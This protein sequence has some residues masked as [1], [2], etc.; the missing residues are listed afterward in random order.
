MLLCKCAIIF[1]ILESDLFCILKNLFL[2]SYCNY[3]Q[4]ILFEHI[5]EDEITE[6]EAFVRNEMLNVILDN[7]ESIDENGDTKVNK[8]KMIEYFGELYALK[9]EQ[10]RFQPGDR[11]FIK[12]IQQTIT[13]TIEKKGRKRAMQHFGYK[14]KP[15]AKKML[16]DNQSGHSNTDDTKCAT[17]DDECTTVDIDL[18]KKMKAK[19]FDS[20]LDKLKTF[21]IPQN[22]IEMF[23]DSFISVYVGEDGMVKGDVVCVVCHAKKVQPKKNKPNHVYCR[24]KSGNLS[25]VISNFVKHFQRVHSDIKKC[26]KKDQ[27]SNELPSAINANDNS[28]SSENASIGNMSRDIMDMAFESTIIEMDSVEKQLN[29]EISKQIVK[30]WSIHT[31]HGD[32]LESEVQCADINNSRISFDVVQICGNGDCLFSSAA[33]QLFGKDIKSSEHTILTQN[34]RKNVVKYIQEHYEDFIFY[35]RGHVQELKEIATK[36]PSCDTYGFN[37]IDNIDDACKYFVDECLIKPGFWAGAE[38]L[39]A[40]HFVHK[41]DIIVFIEDGP[42]TFYNNNNEQVNRIITLAYRLSADRISYNHYDSVCNMAHEVIYDTAN[43]ISN[44]L[45]QNNNS[46]LVLDETQ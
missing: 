46:I 9:P 8:Q 3:T 29:E 22:L 2:C 23:N 27:L 15:P 36:N 24:E 6:V 7:E 16:K 33:H 35:V 38:S 44:R 42:I 39:K 19:L 32:D 31:I 43:V 10:F 14:C 1:L 41:V 20:I 28:C 45:K 18:K 34:L 12:L 40:I 17:A 5:T 13:T 11:K 37:S 26:E 4:A 21:K 30:M 25:W